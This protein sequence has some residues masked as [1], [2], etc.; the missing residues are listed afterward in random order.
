MTEA[1]VELVVG[2]LPD[3]A[4]VE[5]HDVGIGADGSPL[6]SRLLE[7][8]S[9]PFGVVH[10]HLAAVGPDLIGARNASVAGGGRRLARHR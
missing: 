5:H 4:G 2:V 1:A 6:V 7:Q 3:R 9:K 10:V 8:A